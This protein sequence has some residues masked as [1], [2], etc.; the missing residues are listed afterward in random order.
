MKNALIL[1]V[2]FLSQTSLAVSFN[3][4]QQILMSA[5]S[6]EVLDSY[7][8]AIISWTSSV[9]K[10]PYEV[11]E[12]YCSSKS[13]QMDVAPISLYQVKE[14]TNYDAN[15]AMNSAHNG[16]NCFNAALVF[17]QTLPNVTFTHP[18]EMSAVL[19]SS[20]CRERESVEPLQPGDILV[21]RNQKDVLLDIHAGI[22]INDKLSYSKYGQNSMMPY[23][24][25]LDVDKS[26]GVRDEA[27]RRVEGTPMPGDVCYEKPYVNFY[28]CGPLYSFISSLTRQPGGINEVARKIY[29]DTSSADLKIS[30][31]AFKGQ[32]IEREDLKELQVKIQELFVHASRVEGDKTLSAGDQ[33]LVRLMRFRLFSLYEQTRI[34]ARDR[35][36]SDLLG[37]ALRID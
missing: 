27:C 5:P 26:Y 33:E 37:P 31:V 8:Q 6:C 9:S 29:A 11:P 34:I 12:C 13:C 10:T 36:D 21:V 25:G 32:K 16:P 14:F 15:Y 1:F 2:V 23:S 19:E 35:K 20:L 30:N 22:Y 4:T 17:T 7:A 24:Y 3:P 28:S 18:Y